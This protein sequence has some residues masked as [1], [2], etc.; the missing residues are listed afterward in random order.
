MKRI[1]LAATFVVLIGAALPATASALTRKQA[2]AIAMRTLHPKAGKK[3]VILFSL[4]KPLKAG[5]RV[6]PVS[7]VK[8]KLGKKVRRPGTRLRHAAWL[9]WLDQVPYAKFSHPSRYLLV[10][11]VTGRVVKQARTQWYPAVN[12]RPPAFLASRKAYAAKRYRVFVRFPRRKARALEVPFHSSLL[13]FPFAWPRANVPAGALK[14]ECV[15]IISAFGDSQFQNDYDAFSDW[16]RSHKIPTYFLTGDGLDK[17]IPDGTSKPAD[18]ESLLDG[19]AR[20][21]AK[22]GCTDIL[23]YMSGHGLDEDEG[24]ASVV[25]RIQVDQS[26]L[27]PTVTVNA[28]TASAVAVA[29]SLNPTA[30]FKL[31]VDSCYSGRFRDALTEVE[32]G[33][34]K[35]KFKNLL[36]LE[37]SS[38]ADEVSAFGNPLVDGNDNP[39]NVSE[40]TNQNL[41]G[42]TKFFDSQTLIDKAVAEG[43]SLMAH[44]L[45]EGFDLGASVNH[46]EDEDGDKIDPQKFTN[47]G[48]PK[49][50][51]KYIGAVFPTQPFTTTY[52]AVVTGQ[53][54]SY[55]WAVSI[56]ADP[57]CAAGFTPNSPKPDQATWYHADVG[58]G[59]PCTHVGTD[60]PGTV[61]LVVT[62]ADWECTALYQG[63]L[64]GK[65]PPAAPCKRR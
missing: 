34:R 35:S 41:T 51:L 1:F 32:G 39:N 6:V 38:A 62:N 55:H 30:D 27:I 7:P 52:T 43:G 26:T 57:A 63:T 20:L 50:D 23:I 15:L 16:S 24:P 59:G 37:N 49:P 5:T 2:N 8:G 9:F 54:L 25:T 58:E 53:G 56:L 4:P 46:A 31:K 14:G 36:I 60:H 47:L 48:L 10:D 61:F 21:S 64:S 11:D 40:F 12:G 33:K 3:H 42:L 28:I 29:V 22:E 18:N 44:A 13:S 45:D 19:V 17:V 65:G